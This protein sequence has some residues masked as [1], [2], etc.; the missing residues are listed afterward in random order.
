M[1]I[2]ILEVVMLMKVV[3]A[4]MVVLEA[5]VDGQNIHASVNHPQITAGIETTRIYL[6]AHAAP[7]Q[8]LRLRL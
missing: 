4:V 5:M 7:L 1:V 3:E 2:V 6:T 8:C